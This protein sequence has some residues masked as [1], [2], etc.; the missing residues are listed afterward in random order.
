ME[1]GKMK[2]YKLKKDDGKELAINFIGGALVALILAILGM[3]AIDDIIIPI[4]F[5]ISF[6]TFIGGIFKWVFRL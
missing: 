6:I 2:L 5:I 3:P 4:F 1:V